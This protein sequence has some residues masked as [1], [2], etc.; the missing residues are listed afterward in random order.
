MRCLI[1]CA[2]VIVEIGEHHIGVLIEQG[3]D[4]VGELLAAETRTHEIKGAVELLIVVVAVAGRIVG[5]VLLGFGGGH[6]ED[7]DVVVAHRLM[8]FHIGTVLGAE[9]NSA[10]HHE[11]HVAGAAGFRA[12]ERNLLADFG[13]GNEFFR[14]GHAV[15]LQIDHLE[16]IG[17]AFVVVDEVGER[18]DELN[19]LLGEEIAGGCL[20]AED[21]GLGG[22]GLVGMIKQPLVLREN[23]QR[24]EVLAL[25]LMEPLDLHVK[26]GVGIDEN[27][28]V[29]ED[30]V[31]HFHLALMLDGG[32]LFKNG[33]VVAILHQTFEPGSILDEAVADETGNQFRQFGIALIE[34]AA[35]GDAVGDVGEFVRHYGVEVME[36]TVLDDLAVQRG[37]AVDMMAGC[38]TEV[39]HLDPAVAD[40]AHAGDFFIIVAGGDIHF[41]AEAAVDFTDDLIDTGQLGAE[42]ILIPA[43][44]RFRHNGVIGISHDLR[45]QLPRLVPVKAA[46]V[47]EQAHEFGDGEG[48]MSVVNVNG[49]ELG[50]VFHRT[51]V[52]A[53]VALHDVL[54]RSG[55]EEVLL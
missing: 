25:V 44:Q 30:I 26:D 13:G 37:N 5:L 31:R 17:Y 38:H 28:V 34:P 52:S 23:M 8:D 50:E 19:D 39:C 9:G 51:A 22:K 33:L 48:G 6:T 35:M 16:F 42:E 40:D 32:E 36:H 27:A 20:G 54:H 2:A 15:I 41:I 7:D 45:G 46:L 12:C 1:L 14:H 55:H 47:H 49:V 11:L 18:A 3:V 4:H 29:L 21:I 10:V 24:V 43:F 53:Q